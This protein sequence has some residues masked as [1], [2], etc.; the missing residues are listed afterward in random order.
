MWLQTDIVDLWYFKLFMLGP[1]VS[2]KFHKFTPLDGKDIGIKK[3]FVIIAQ[4]LPNF[5]IDFWY[6]VN[7]INFWNVVFRINFLYVV[8]RINSWY[9]LYMIN[10][11]TDLWRFDY[12]QLTFEFK[13]TYV[14][15]LKYVKV[16][17]FQD[18]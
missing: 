13:T 1:I 14:L 7:R 5:K 6:V 10:L 11:I 16:K 2:L 8:F 15:W 18:W 4:L 9:V 17:C 12:F 3:W